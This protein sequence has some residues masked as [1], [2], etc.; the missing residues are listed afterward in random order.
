M[1]DGHEAIPLPKSAVWEL[2]AI[3]SSAVVFAVWL[4]P[5][6]FEGLSYALGGTLFY[7][8]A[9]ALGRR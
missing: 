8:F 6:P 5:L 1:S 4:G 3:M 7:V 9:T 2:A